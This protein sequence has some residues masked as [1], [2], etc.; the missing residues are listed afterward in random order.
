VSSSQLPFT[1]LAL[2]VPLALGLALIV[3]GLALRTRVRRRDAG[4]H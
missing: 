3:F 2:W 4:A 1:G